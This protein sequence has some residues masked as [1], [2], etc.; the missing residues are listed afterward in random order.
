MAENVAIFDFNVLA[1]L[2]VRKSFFFRLYCSE[3]F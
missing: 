1:G 3:E 2:L